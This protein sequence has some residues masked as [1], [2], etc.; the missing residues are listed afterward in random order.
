MFSEKIGR[1]KKKMK[2]LLIIE[3]KMLLVGKVEQVVRIEK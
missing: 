2:Q 1:K 3:K